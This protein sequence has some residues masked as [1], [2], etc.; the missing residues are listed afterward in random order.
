MPRPDSTALFDRLRARGSPPD[1]I[2]AI[3]S[4]GICALFARNED[5]LP[6]L[7]LPASGVIYIGYSGRMEQRD[8]FT[9]GSGFS[10]LR[11]SLGAILRELLRL[12]AKPRSPGS[13]ESDIHNFRFAG[14]VSSD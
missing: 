3:T 5:G 10:T 12:M 1:S 4:P 2:P 9:M 14:E 11:R 8:H 13:D 6:G 7:V